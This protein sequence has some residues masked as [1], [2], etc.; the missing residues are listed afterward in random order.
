MGSEGT[1]REPEGVRYIRDSTPLLTFTFFS[2]CTA[3]AFA[4]IGLVLGRF[5][6]KEAFSHLR[7]HFPHNESVPRRHVIFHL[8]IFTCHYCLKLKMDRELWDD[9]QTQISCLSLLSPLRTGQRSLS[10][11]RVPGHVTRDGREMDKGK[12]NHL[13]IY[14]DS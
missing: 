11:C 14:L 5:N 2:C 6:L 3:L 7:Y 9:I 4:N 12:M 1:T 13:F 8:A 10:L